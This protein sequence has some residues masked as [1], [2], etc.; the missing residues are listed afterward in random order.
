MPAACLLVAVDA[1]VAVT[2]PKSL[3]L[4]IFWT[5]VFVRW[6][7]IPPCINAVCVRGY[8]RHCRESLACSLS[9]GRRCK[10]CLCL[11]L[12]GYLPGNLV[13]FE[14]NFCPLEFVQMP[15]VEVHAYDITELLERLIGEV[16]DG[17]CNRQSQ[18]LAGPQPVMALVLVLVY[19]Y[20]GNA[21]N[22]NDIN[23]DTSLST[24]ISYNPVI[25]V[26]LFLLFPTFFFLPGYHRYI[27]PKD[28]I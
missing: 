1:E 22:N 8:R 18:L 11:S 21:I 14:S 5:L 26:D 15:P 27:W 24:S 4:L 7:R 13:Y 3:R 10:K 28:E 9:A 23:L 12:S 16:L 2:T 25:S 20:L 19:F 17:V 6:M